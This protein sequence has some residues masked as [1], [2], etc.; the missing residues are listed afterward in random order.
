MPTLTNEHIRRH[1]KLEIDSKALHRHLMD[2]KHFFVFVN[3][4][5]LKRLSMMTYIFVFNFV[6]K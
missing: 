5:F 2:G 4:N 3:Y 1:L 6:M